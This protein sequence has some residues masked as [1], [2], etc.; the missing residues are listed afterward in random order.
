[1][2][3]NKEISNSLAELNGISLQPESP[4]SVV[5][6]LSEFWHSEAGEED[7]KSEPSTDRISDYGTLDEFI[8]NVTKKDEWKV[9]S[10][11]WSQSEEQLAKI[12]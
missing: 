9:F 8:E 4:K 5:F 3:K 7:W 11:K 2:D 1:M 10:S 6:K 12:D